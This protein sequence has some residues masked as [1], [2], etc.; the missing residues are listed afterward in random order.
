MP[1]YAAFHLCLHCLP[2]NLFAGI[3]NEKG[4]KSSGQFLRKSL[5]PFILMD[6]PR[7]AVIASFVF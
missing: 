7:C 6:F 1:P 3:R 2:K 5:N 4:L